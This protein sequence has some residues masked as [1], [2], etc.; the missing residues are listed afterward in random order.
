[1]TDENAGSPA[2]TAEQFVADNDRFRMAG[3][4]DSLS[5]AHHLDVSVAFVD[6]FGIAILADAT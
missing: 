3:A 1:M 5:S 6:A 4:V 2:T